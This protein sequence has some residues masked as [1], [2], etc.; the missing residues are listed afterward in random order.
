MTRGA[1][2]SD[3]GGPHPVVVLLAEVGRAELAQFPPR[4][5]VVGGELAVLEADDLGQVLAQQAE[6]PAD[7]DD[8]DG[9]EHLVQHQHARVEGRVRTGIH[10][11]AAFP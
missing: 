3:V 4:R 8:V 6:R 7:G 9:H 5:E 11:G 10:S 2:I 1:W